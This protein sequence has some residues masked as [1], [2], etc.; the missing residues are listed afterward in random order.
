MMIKHLF[1]KMF[2][3]TPGVTVASLHRGVT[4]AQII[5]SM[6]TIILALREVNLQLHSMIQFM[7]LFL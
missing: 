4:T 2:N 3:L 5:K 7:P 1:S 6:I